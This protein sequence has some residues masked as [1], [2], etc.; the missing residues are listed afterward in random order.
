MNCNIG[1]KEL[2]Y[3]S[4]ILLVGIA[5]LWGCPKKAEVTTSPQAQTQSENRKSLAAMS[6]GLR[7]IYFDFGKSFIRNDAKAVM[8]ANAEWIKANPTTTVKIE[9]NRDER[10]HNKALSR[11]RAMSAKKYLTR[12]GI[13][14]H[15]IS[16]TS[17]GK[18]KPICSEQ[19][20][21]CWRMNR[22]DDFVVAD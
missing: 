11:R 5:T 4:F 19:D 3:L 8:K 2:L 20:E 7:P 21:T 9:G 1:R 15:R 14:R 17:N 6:E 10:E 16:L 22:R 18:E 12:M 13:S